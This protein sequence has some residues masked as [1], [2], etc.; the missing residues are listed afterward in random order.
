MTILKRGVLTA[1]AGERLLNI[2]SG[3]EEIGRKVKGRRVIRWHAVV[4][5][6]GA[7]EVRTAST[8]GAPVSR[9]HHMADSQFP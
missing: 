6:R 8:M 3:G 9:V 1:G 5:H 2:V 7:V 4:V